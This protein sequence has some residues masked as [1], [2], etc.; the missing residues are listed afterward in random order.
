MLKEEDDAVAN[1]PWENGALIE[2]AG[3]IPITCFRIPE[4]LKPNKKNASE[5]N[6]KDVENSGAWP[7]FC[8]KASFNPK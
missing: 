4:D 2:K 5:P 6:F 1:D 8:Y 7:E 3:D